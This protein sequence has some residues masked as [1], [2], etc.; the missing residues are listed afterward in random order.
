VGLQARGQLSLR[1]AGAVVGQISN[2]SFAT[3]AVKPRH[4]SGMRGDIGTRLLLG[5]SSA[6]VRKPARQFG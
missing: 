6:S 4:T 1:E 5:P 3:F 2:A